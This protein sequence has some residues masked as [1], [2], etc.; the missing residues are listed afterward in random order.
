MNIRTATNG[1]TKELRVRDVSRG[2]QFA[3]RVVADRSAAD[4][5]ARVDKVSAVATAHAAAVD[6]ASRFPSEA[7]AAARA[8]RLMGIAVPRE[9]GGEGFGTADVVDVCY[10]LGRSCAS[11]A[12]IYAMHQTKVACITRHGRSS[13]WHQLL[14]RRLCAEQL[15]LASSTTEGQ[16]GGDVRNSAAAIEGD[17]RITLE[18]QA[19]VISYGEAADGIVTTARRSADAASS[20][21]VLVVFLKEDY[22]LDRLNGWDAFGMRG[23]CSSGFKLVA[24][25]LREQI[26][27]VSYE[28]IHS[29]TMM[30]FAHLAWSGAWA[31]IAAAAVDRARAFVRKAAQ[32]SGGALPPGAA[33]LTRANANLRTLRS[34]IA[35]ALQRFEAASADAAA[36]EFIEFQTG[37]NMHKVSASELAV[38]TVMSAMQ[39]CGLAGYRNDSEFSVGR[40][41]RDILSSPIMI[42]NDRILANAATASLLAGPPASLRD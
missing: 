2:I 35:A 24:S 28:K 19:T 9:L 31:G 25:G 38:S 18:R 13:A 32:R 42:S 29:H 34:L 33:H 39:A 30:P 40:H 21:Q 10:T 4:L 8:E 23:T 17:T 27:P 7:I 1:V 22:A 6:G 14:L 26:L 36:L 15:L 16:A 11:T 37:M 12:M 41:L 20:D 3:E 5:R